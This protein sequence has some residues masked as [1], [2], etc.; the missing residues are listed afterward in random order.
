M[1]RAPPGDHGGPDGKARKSLTH[2]WNPLSERSTWHPVPASPLLHSHT[3]VGIYYLSVHLC[4]PAADEPPA[5]EANEAAHDDDRGD[6]D[7]RDRAG[8]EGAFVGAGRFARGLFAVQAVPR[9]A[10]ANVRAG[11]GVARAVGLAALPVELYLLAGGRAVRAGL[12]GTLSGAR[13]A[14]RP[15]FTITLFYLTLRQDSSVA[16]SSKRRCAVNIRLSYRGTSTRNKT[17]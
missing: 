13:L 1:Q 6:G 3:P 11:R 5:E 14:A 16:V 10:R 8:R 2:R 17:A 7:P 12:S 15:T 9:V 4:L